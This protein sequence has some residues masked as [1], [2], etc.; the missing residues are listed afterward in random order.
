MLSKFF[1]FYLLFWLLGNLS[2][3]EPEA[4]YTILPV[5]I[6]ITIFLSL[7][8]QKYNVLSL[9]NETA[10]HLGIDSKLLRKLSY[11]LSSGLVGLAVSVS[12]IIGFIGLLVPHTCRIIFGF[13]NRVLIPASFFAGAVFL[14]IADTL[15][16]TLISPSEIPVG[17]ITAVIGA[18]LFIYLLKS[19]L[20]RYGMM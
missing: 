8:G 9:G 16:R 18:P 12:G 1:L 2:L 6:L 11:I 15:A 4:A 3:A 14:I 10:K 5:T 17:V 20:N 13:D 19:R 7:N